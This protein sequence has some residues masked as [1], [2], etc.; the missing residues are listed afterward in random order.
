MLW[1]DASKELQFYGSTHQTFALWFLEMSEWNQRDFSQTSSLPMELRLTH[2]EV[3]PPHRWAL[4]VLPSPLQE[5]QAHVVLPPQ[6]VTSAVL[7]SKM[8]CKASLFNTLVISLQE[9]H[10]GRRWCPESYLC[11]YVSLHVS[12]NGPLFLYSE[13]LSDSKRRI[14]VC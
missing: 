11:L 1:D 3:S 5:D 13:L 9:I 4:L 14:Y 6:M 12:S 7:L 8:H 2:D 10:S